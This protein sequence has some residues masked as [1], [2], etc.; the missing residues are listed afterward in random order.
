MLQEF[1]TDDVLQ[2]YLTSLT[3]VYDPHSDY[4]G[5]RHGQLQHR[6]K[7]SLFGIGALLRSEDG[8]CKIQELKRSSQEEGKVKPKDRIVAVA[9]GTNRRW[10]S[11]TGS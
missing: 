1:D 9:Q 3:Q 7:L 2:I 4:M 10:M 6:M 5:A 11:S 8:Y